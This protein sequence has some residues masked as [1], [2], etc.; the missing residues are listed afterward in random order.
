MSLFLH[1]VAVTLHLLRITFDTT[2][3]SV[4]KVTVNC[5]SQIRKYLNIVRYTLQS[6][7]SFGDQKIIL[8]ADYYDNLS[9]CSEFNNLSPMYQ[10]N[11]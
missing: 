5:I 10:P 4:I 2:V 3:Y 6:F 11:C 7:S 1:S 9:Q 8:D